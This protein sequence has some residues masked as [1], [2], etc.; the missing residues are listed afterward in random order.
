MSR[1][2]LNAGTDSDRYTATPHIKAGYIDIST[3]AVFRT[4]KDALNCFGYQKGHYQRAAW[5]IP[6]EICDVIELP[7][8]SSVWFPTLDDNAAWDNSLSDDGLLIIEKKKEAD[9][10]RKNDWEYRIVMAKSKDGYNRTLYR[11]IGVFEVVPGYSV[12][13]EHRFRRVSTTVKTYQS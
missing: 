6:D 4:H 3:N 2:K 9:D 7:Y 11:F 1:D 10:F 5:K 12:G 8:N 13:N